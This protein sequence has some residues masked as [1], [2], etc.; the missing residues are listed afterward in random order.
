MSSEK[1]NAKFYGT[2]R[3]IDMRDDLHLVTDSQDMEAISEYLGN[4]EWFK[5]FDGCFVKVGEGEYEEIYCF[6]GIIP[7]L[8]KPLYKIIEVVNNE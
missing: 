2:I 5:D 6:E 3:S 1:Y 8:D 4:P 7:D